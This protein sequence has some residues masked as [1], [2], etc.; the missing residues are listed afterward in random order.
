MLR[1]IGI[2]ITSKATNEDTESQTLSIVS[3]SNSEASDTAITEETTTMEDDGIVDIGESKVIETSLVYS[4]DKKRYNSKVEKVEVTKKYDESYGMWYTIDDS[5][6]TAN[7]EQIPMRDIMD[8]NMNMIGDVS[9]VLV[10]LNITDMNSQLDSQ[11]VDIHEYTIANWR[12]H[13]LD[14]RADK[15]FPME[16]YGFS[17]DEDIDT[18]GNLTLEGG[19]SKSVTLLYLVEDCY[20]NENLYFKYSHPGGASKNILYDIDVQ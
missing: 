9:Y 11:E 16:I 20:I 1:D 3:Q 4:T 17:Y 13:T 18:K 2:N 7:W 12:I 10:T 14:E 19:E 8:E 5:F 6:M 15:W